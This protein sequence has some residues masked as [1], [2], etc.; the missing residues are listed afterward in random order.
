MSVEVNWGVVFNGIATIAALLLTIPFRDFLISWLGEPPIPGL[1]YLAAFLSGLILV[2]SIKI[3]IM[4]ILVAAI[5]I[6]EGN[7]YFFKIKN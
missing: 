6:S 3:I 1:A 4:L 7:F 2:F 5:K